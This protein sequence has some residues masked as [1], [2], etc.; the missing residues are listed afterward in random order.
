MR[1]LAKLA[2]YVGLA[3]VAARVL[4]SHVGGWGGW[5]ATSG[6]APRAPAGAT[7]GDA[8][9]CAREFPG[10]RWPTVTAALSR[11][12]VAICPTGYSALWSP[13]SRAPILVAEHLD[14]ARVGAARRLERVDEFHPEP[15]LPRG[16][17]AE[18][19]DF[20]RSG[21]DRGHMA[22]NGDMPDREAAHASFSTANLVAQ[23]PQSNRGLWAELESAVRGLATRDGDVYVVT[24]PTF[25]GESVASLGGRVLV[26]TRLW[27]AVWD[28][29][30]GAG[31]YVAP[32]A[33]GWE[34]EVV[35][36]AELTRRT[37]VDPF[38]GLDEGPRTT[39]AALPAPGGQ[40]RRVAQ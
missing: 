27:K 31:A 21:Y 9:G 11:E 32:N 22:P 23:S 6:V 38:P 8:A 34:Y 30:L 3:L 25:E 28:P 36:I 20:A 40:H 4:P 37:G 18:L 35:S 2:L 10:G 19:S 29:S 5:R 26:P 1:R 24:G 13:L 16:V 7:G 17:R 15:S 33:P 39:A 12:A 14:A